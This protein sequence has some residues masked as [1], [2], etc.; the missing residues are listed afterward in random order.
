[1]EE[2][3]CSYEIAKLLKEKGFDCKCTSWYIP[4]ED[5]DAKKFASKESE[6]YN[7]NHAGWMVS[8]PTHQM[9]CA[10]LRERNVNICMMIVPW[11]GKAWWAYSIYRVEPFAIGY[12]DD[13]DNDT[14]YYE[15]YEEA[16]EAAIKYS[17]EN[18]I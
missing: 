2:A 10:W 3:Y 12:V 1:M 13:G 18:L 6:D 5:G 15:T 9:A 11:K 16:V 4:Y 17:L 8:C 7:H 14:Q